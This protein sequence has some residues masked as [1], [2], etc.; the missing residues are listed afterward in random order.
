MSPTISGG[1]AGGLHDEDDTSAHEDQVN[2]DPYHEAVD[3]APQT[4]LPLG[5][6]LIVYHPHAQK[7]PE[8]VD[9]AT[10]FTAELEDPDYLD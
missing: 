9:S 6:T 5:K 3:S 4:I 2:I 8:I 7:M 1:Y 10:Q